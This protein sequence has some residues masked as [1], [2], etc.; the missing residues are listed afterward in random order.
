MATLISDEGLS[1]YL[2][3]INK[4]PILTAEEEFSLATKLQSTGDKEVAHKLVTSHLR[5]VTKIALDYRGYGLPLMDLI[6]EGNI[7][8]M[9]AVKKFDLEKGFRL[10]TY[11]MWWIKA[12]INDYVLKSWSMVKIGSSNSKK[13]LFFNLKRLK[14]KMLQNSSYENLS[15]QEVLKIATELDVSTSDVVDMDILLHDNKKSLNSPVSDEG[16]T[17]ELIDFIEDKTTTHDLVVSETQELDSRRKKFFIE[18]EKL[19]E[20]EKDILLQRRMTEPAK[21]LEELSQ[22]HG[23]S[24]ERIRQIENKT[25]DKLKKLVAEIH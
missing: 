8:L 5:L 4:F 23:V 25:M 3:Q 7:G 24:K 9:K 15:E 20:R 12:S 6:A 21:T 14:N 19:N 18:F 17:A 16:S 22:K 2:A 1:A 11:A 13:K 10:S